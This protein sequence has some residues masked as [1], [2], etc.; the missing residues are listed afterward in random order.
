MSH[1]ELDNQ[2]CVYAEKCRG[3]SM[4]KPSGG[5]LP[6]CVAHSLLVAAAAAFCPSLQ[7]ATDCVLLACLLPSLW[8]KQARIITT[9]WAHVESAQLLIQP[10]NE[11]IMNCFSGRTVDDEM[12]QAGGLSQDKQFSTNQPRLKTVSTTAT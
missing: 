12:S 7:V 1:A 8:E 11:S 9:I 2:G 5:L 6:A 4:C 3:W 10:I